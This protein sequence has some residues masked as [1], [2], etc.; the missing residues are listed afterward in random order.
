MLAKLILLLQSKAA[1]SVVG[2]V[3]LTSGAA[4]TVATTTG[5]VPSF[6]PGRAA[7]AVHRAEATPT[8]GATETP[9][10]ENTA[11]PSETG[12][13][14]D[15]ATPDATATAGETPTP[16]GHV[17]AVLGVLLAYDPAGDTVTVQAGDAG[18]PTTIAVNDST[19][20]NGEHANALADL[21]NNLQHGVEISASR[22]A[23][24]SL[25]ALKITVQ[26]N[27]GSA[28][29][30]TRGGDSNH[31]GSSTSGGNGDGHGG[32]SSGGDRGGSSGSGSTGGDRAGS[33]GGTDDSS[34]TE[35][36]SR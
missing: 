29:G 36:S 10:T 35:G 4:V 27:E 31:G 6:V 12:T 8:A 30:A 20:V 28:G 13:P 23:D 7:H 1:V 34:G 5:H 11:V 17:V 22:Q 2:A 25:L 16:E 26:G 18:A 33:R 14:D 32:G 9:E 15:A 19:R 24:G 21:A 3:V